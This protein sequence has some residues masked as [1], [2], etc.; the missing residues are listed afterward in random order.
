MAARIGRPYELQVLSTNG[1][2]K[3]QGSPNKPTDMVADVL[4]K[5][6]PRD[7][8]EKHSDAMGLHSACAKKTPWGAEKEED[9]IIID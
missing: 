8:H 2:W 9:F 5:P 3:L 6:L 1:E 4:T 7:K